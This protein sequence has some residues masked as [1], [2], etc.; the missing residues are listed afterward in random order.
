[1]TVTNMQYIAIV[2]SSVA[3][4]AYAATVN[5]SPAYVETI[6]IQLGSVTNVSRSEWLL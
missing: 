6:V 5:S 2:N 1:M 4:K 3:Y